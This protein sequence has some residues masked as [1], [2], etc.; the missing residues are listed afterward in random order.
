MKAQRFWV[1]ESEKLSIE[2]VLQWSL[3]CICRNALSF[4]SGLTEVALHT[5]CTSV[6]KILQLE[7]VGLYLLL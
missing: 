5:S 3:G 7:I 1:V 4:V 2:Q 6:I